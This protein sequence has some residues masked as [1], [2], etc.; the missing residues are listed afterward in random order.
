MR[1]ETGGKMANRQEDLLDR[2]LR[3]MLDNLHGAYTAK[4]PTDHQKAGQYC[5]NSGTCILVCCY[6]NALG[7]VLLKGGPPREHRGQRVRQ[8]F[9]LARN[10]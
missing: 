4:Y 6:I 9:E 1:R 5:V 7:K 10:V 2:T 8:D 3:W